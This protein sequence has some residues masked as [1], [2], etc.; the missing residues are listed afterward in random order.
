MFMK[1]KAQQNPIRQTLIGEGTHLAD[2]LPVPVSIPDTHR[3]GHIFTMGATRSGKTRLAEWIIEQD[4]RKG[5]PVLWIDP[6]GDIQILSK[7][8][9]VAREV[10]REREFMFLSPI[11]PD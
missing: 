11:F 10:G 6:K 9:Q 5:Y 4:I 2:T 1:K 8:A 3:Q 7:I